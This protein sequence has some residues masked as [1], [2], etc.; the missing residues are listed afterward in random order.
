[1]SDVPALRTGS[2]LRSQVCTTEVIVVRPGAGS[3]SLTCGG[4]PLVELTAPKAEG[5]SPAAGLDGGSL[6]GKRYTADS[7]ETLEILVTKAGDGTLADGAT[8]LVL[9]DAKPL[10]ASD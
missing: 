1:M 8:P 5:V 6:L 10:P 7:D 2:R 3:V 4:Q 9:K